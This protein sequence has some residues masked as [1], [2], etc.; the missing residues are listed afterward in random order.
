MFFV[1][2]SHVPASPVHQQHELEVAPDCRSCRFADSLVV[3]TA[4]RSQLTTTIITQLAA[5]YHSGRT[6]FVILFVHHVIN[7]YLLFIHVIHDS[8]SLRTTALCYNLL[9]H[10]IP[11]KYINDEATHAGRH[12]SPEGR[13]L[14]RLSLAQQRRLQEL[15]HESR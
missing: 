12:H 11:A 6:L 10:H 5:C 4:N 13:I 7:A 14:G 9:L 2:N 1:S 8:N 3:N 15:R